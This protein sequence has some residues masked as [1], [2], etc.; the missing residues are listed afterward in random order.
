MRWS[1]IDFQ[2]DGDLV[3]VGCS[4]RITSAPSNHSENPLDGFIIG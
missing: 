3:T 1:P 4:I 2:L